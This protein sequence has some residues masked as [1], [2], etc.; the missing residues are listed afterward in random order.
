MANVVVT[1]ADVVDEVEAVEEDVCGAAVVVPNYV[2]SLISI[3]NFIVLK[4]LTIINRAIV[5]T[6]TIKTWA[7]I[8]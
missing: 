7:N 1:V 8:S 2:F 5:T 6:E 4:F 3:K